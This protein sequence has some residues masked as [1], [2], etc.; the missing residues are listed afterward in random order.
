MARGGNRAVFSRSD[1]RMV[2]ASTP[3]L[4][5]AFRTEKIESQR[6]AVALPVTVPRIFAIVRM[7]PI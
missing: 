1:Q 7:S 4:L 5:V 6:S 2:D 3:N